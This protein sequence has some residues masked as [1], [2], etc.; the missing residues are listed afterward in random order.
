[1][2]GLVD[3]VK[4]Y[5]GSC[6]CSPTAEGLSKLANEKFFRY[7]WLIGKEAN[8]RREIVDYPNHPHYNHPKLG[9]PLRDHRD[10]AITGRETIRERL[11]EAYDAWHE[12]ENKWL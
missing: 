5:E 8:L 7:W 6:C 1:M 3:H 10:K 12:E 4:S 2:A 9:K 11:D